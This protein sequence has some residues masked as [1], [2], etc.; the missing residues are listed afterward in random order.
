M[1]EDQTNYN[2]D[3]SDVKV[4]EIKTKIYYYQ[5]LNDDKVIAFLKNHVK[6]FHFG[7]DDFSCDPNIMK[8]T[9]FN[10]KGN[11]IINTLKKGD[12]IFVYN[13]KIATYDKNQ[14]IDLLFQYRKLAS[15]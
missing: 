4:I 5:Y 11:Q 8:I 9:Q 6:L 13:D 14:A 3:L 15:Q 7:K 10:E 2:L 12:Y 1:S